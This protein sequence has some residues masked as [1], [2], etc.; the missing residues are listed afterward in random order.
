MYSGSRRGGLI[1]QALLNSGSRRGGLIRQ[2]L[3]YSGSR[4]GGLIRQALLYSGSRRGGLIRQGLCT[5]DPEHTGWPKK[6][7]TETNQNDTDINDN[8]V[9]TLYYVRTLNK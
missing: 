8:F 3:L 7:N 4:R 1:R 9:T 6:T 5:V 2:A